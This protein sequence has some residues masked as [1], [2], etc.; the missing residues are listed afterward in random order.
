[1][2]TFIELYRY[3]Q[4]ASSG[5]FDIN[6]TSFNITLSLPVQKQDCPVI[7]IQYRTNVTE[8]P[9]VGNTQPTK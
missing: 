2:Y 9:G 6:Q 4:S 1:M 8:I 3:P 7:T 5:F